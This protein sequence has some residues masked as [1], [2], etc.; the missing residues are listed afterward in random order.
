M[1]IY[2]AG[3][4]SETM[5]QYIARKEE[6]KITNIREATVKGVFHVIQSEYHRKKLEWMH[7][8]QNLYETKQCVVNTNK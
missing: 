1:S 4:G 6:H 5:Q 7:G 2:R 8:E 3:H